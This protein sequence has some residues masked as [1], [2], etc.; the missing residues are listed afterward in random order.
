LKDYCCK[1]CT[2][3]KTQITEGY[4]KVF[5]KECEQ[6]SFD[7]KLEFAS[8]SSGGI[9]PLKFSKGD[10]DRN[11]RIEIKFKRG[12]HSVV[13]RK[14][15]RSESGGQNSPWR[16]FEVTRTVGS[17]GA[18]WTVRALHEGSEKLREPLDQSGFARWLE[19]GETHHPG[20]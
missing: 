12:E 19:A 1:K 3:S 2:E 20:C 13:A 17:S 14:P 15:F 7:W 11:H 9:T 4:L 18:V 8:E 10:G 6:G 5:H 16:V